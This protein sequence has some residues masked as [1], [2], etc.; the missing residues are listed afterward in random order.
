MF[1][2]LLMISSPTENQLVQTIRW[3]RKTGGFEARSGGDMHSKSGE[4]TEKR[5]CDR[6]E[7]R[8]MRRDQG[9]SMLVHSSTTRPS[10]ESASQLSLRTA[11]RTTRRYD[12]YLVVFGWRTWRATHGSVFRHQ[13]QPVQ[14]QLRH[15][16]SV[17][18]TTSALQ[19]VACS[20]PTAAL[21]R[22]SA[23]VIFG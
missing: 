4:L 16:M 19:T 23:C 21:L 11:D 14:C 10:S 12:C 13:H 9:H 2:C 5:R 20:N 15:Q 22:L 6:C 8:W 18:I 1:E 17:G 7:K 3:E